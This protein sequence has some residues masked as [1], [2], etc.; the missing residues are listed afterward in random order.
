MNFRFKIILS[1]VLFLISYE[2][3]FSQ[4]TYLGL[5]QEG[6]VRSAQNDLIN[7]FGTYWPESQVI[8]NYLY[9]PTTNGIYRK[10]LMNLNDTIWELHGFEGIPI[11]DFIKNNDTI[12]VATARYD[13]S[14]LLLL[15]TNNGVSYID[16]TP[17]D[18]LNINPEITILRLTQNPLNPQK[19]AAMH[20]GLGVSLSSDFGQ[21]WELSNDF[22]GGYQDWFLGFNP[23]DTANIFHTGEQIFFQSYIFSTYNDGVTWTKV[24]S[25]QT[26]CTH[27]IAFHPTNKDIMI[28]YGE[29]RFAKSTNQGQHWSDVGSISLYIFKVIFDPANPNILYAS[30]DFQGVNDTVRIYKSTDMGDSWQVFY[31]E[32]IT[33]ADGVMDIHL[34]DDKLI[35]Y[36]LVN[37]V[38]YLD[39]N[40]TIGIKQNEFSPLIIYPN[41]SDNYVYIKSDYSINSVSIIDVSGKIQYESSVADKETYIDLTNLTSGMYFIVV[42][43]ENGQISRIIT[44]E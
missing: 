6:N 41:P 35:I 14:G 38:Y 4:M 43:T 17:A 28:S 10:N 11:R 18:F 33:E 21:T 36:T 16:Y 8:D 29:G 27:G 3:V 44:K 30:G 25:L 42:E 26:H 7:V 34:F 32:K 15:S 19:I 20:T 1:T 5:K 13:N 12:L 23:N 37:G 31:E 22:I 40:N 24:D 9:I 2:I 39:I